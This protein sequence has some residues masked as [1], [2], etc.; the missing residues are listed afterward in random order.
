ML[1]VYQQ[2]IDLCR[3]QQ[4]AQV[5]QGHPKNRRPDAEGQEI[6]GIRPSTSDQPL[7][8]PS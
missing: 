1:Q 7:S 3:A 6:G 8:L 4:E 2:P 5:Q